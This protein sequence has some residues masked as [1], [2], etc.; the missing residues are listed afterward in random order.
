[1][2]LSVRRVVTGHNPQHKA[3]VTSDEILGVTT[4]RPG[5]QGVVVWAT[6]RIPADNL[7][8][9][10]GSRNTTDTTMQNGIVFLVVR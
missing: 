3:V 6:D 8:P 5:Q 7:D 9:A 1:M 4:R 2:D 10:D